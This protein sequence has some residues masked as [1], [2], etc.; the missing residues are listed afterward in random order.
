MSCSPFD[1]RDYFFGE[2]APAERSAA[3][4]HIATCVSCR[5][6]LA[7]LSDVKTLLLSSMQD[8]E[9]PR[10]IAFASDNVFEPSW[11]QRL[12]S[13][14]PQLGFA[15]AAL[16]ALAIFAHGLLLRPV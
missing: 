11:W 1:L 6:E 15:G 12:W 3:E 7:K 8:E 9:P 2:L 16:L 10:R 5:E 14:G 4:T 13:S